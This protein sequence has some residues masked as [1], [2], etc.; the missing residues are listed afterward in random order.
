MINNRYPNTQL[1]RM[2]PFW[3]AQLAQIPEEVIRGWITELHPEATDIHR[4]TGDGGGHFVWLDGSH[5]CSIALDDPPA[6]LVMK[7]W[8][9]LAVSV[10]CPGCEASDPLNGFTATKRTNDQN[11]LNTRWL[12]DKIDQA[13]AK[14]CPGA[15]GTWQQRAEQLV[16][17]AA[18]ISLPAGEHGDDLRCLLQDILHQ[19]STDSDL[20]EILGKDKYR[21]LADRSRDLLAVLGDQNIWEQ[22]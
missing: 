15:I 1:N 20:D 12:I 18:R 6:W 16:R 11:G 7:S 4:V 19:L 5:C 10:S 9:H 13:H 8:Q 2:G 22:R 14:L 17:K 3:T 21:S